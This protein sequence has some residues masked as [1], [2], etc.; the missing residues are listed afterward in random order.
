MKLSVVVRRTMC[1]LEEEEIQHSSMN[2]RTF[3]W[4]HL[5]PCNIYC[6]EKRYSMV[7]LNTQSTRI[8]SGRTNS[9]YIGNFDTNADLFVT[10]YVP[11]VVIR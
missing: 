1:V 10:G 2:R 4:D 3:E 7:K 11:R 9:I 8:G 6:N 5:W